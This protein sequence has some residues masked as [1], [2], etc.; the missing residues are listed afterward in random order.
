LEW[1]DARLDELAVLGCLELE[2]VLDLHELP[3]VLRLQRLLRAEEV[4]RLCP[5]EVEVALG[6]LD[7]QGVGAGQLTLQAVVVLTF[8]HEAAV[9]LGDQLNLV[10]VLRKLRANGAAFAPLLFGAVNFTLFLRQS[11]LMEAQLYSML[12]GEGL[13]GFGLLFQLGAQSCHLSVLLLHL[14]A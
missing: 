3:L 7:H 1:L 10:I 12:L 11:L 13:H 8:L 2:L 9:E 4:L 6:D 5:Q 14:F